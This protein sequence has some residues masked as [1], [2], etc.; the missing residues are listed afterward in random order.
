M[1]E[2]GSSHEGLGLSILEFFPPKRD[3]GLE[4][5]GLMQALKPPG[6]SA[7]PETS[8]LYQPFLCI[9]LSRESVLNNKAACKEP[10]SSR[11]KPSGPH[12]RQ[13]PHPPKHMPVA[14]NPEPRPCEPPRI[15]NTSTRTTPLQHPPKPRTPNPKNKKSKTPN[16]Q[17]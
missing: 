4:K 14:R 7:T 6:A 1:R 17:P 12:A 13:P 9:K 11:L 16:S 8:R 15:R 3:P 2:L 10:K 5:M